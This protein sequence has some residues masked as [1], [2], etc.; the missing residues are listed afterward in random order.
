MI[1]FSNIE[2]YNGP[3]QVEDLD[4]AVA[5]ALNPDSA[6]DATHTS[7]LI[8]SAAVAGVRSGIASI[9]LTGTTNDTGATISQGTFFYISGTLVTA[10]TDIANGATLTEG[11]NYEAV[12][13]GG[14]NALIAQIMP[15]KRIG[16]WSSGTA[17]IALPRGYGARL[18]VFSSANAANNAFL[19]AQ[20]NG[21]GQ[22]DISQ[23]FKG[24]GITF[25][26]GTGGTLIATLSGTG[27]GVN[28][29]E[30]PLTSY[31]YSTFSI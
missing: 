10:K 17:T 6:P 7:N 26:T 3:L 14:L 21:E 23:I 16:L 4:A 24:N 9:N 29:N 12:T 11:T 13:A 27:N 25:T 2:G 31:K 1:D 30:M 18:I 22:V 5:M 15:F 19:I 28:V 8:T 20:S